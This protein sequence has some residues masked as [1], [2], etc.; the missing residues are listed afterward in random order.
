MEQPDPT[1]E[2]AFPAPSRA[3]ALGLAA[4]AAALAASQASHGWLARIVAGA[5]LL[6]HEAGHLI[7]MPTGLRFLV[8]LGGTLGQLAFPL[9]AAAVFARRREAASLGAALVW[10]GINLVDVGIYAADAQR[11]VLPLLAP[12]IDAHDWWQMLGMLHLRGAADLIGGTIQAAGWAL[13]GAAPA[14]VLGLWLAGWRPGPA[15]HAG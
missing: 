12:S 8:V 6:F 9:V 3:A 10:M 1:E 13:Q 11:R 15:T 4:G 2:P 7:L 5:D 14:W